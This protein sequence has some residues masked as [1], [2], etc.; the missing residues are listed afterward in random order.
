MVIFISNSKKHTGELK[1]FF[2]LNRIGLVLNPQ[3]VMLSCSSFRRE[4]GHRFLICS[5][6]STSPLGANHGASGGILDSCVRVQ[7]PFLF[8]KCYKNHQKHILSQQNSDNP[9]PQNR[10]FRVA[11]FVLFFSAWNS[12]VRHLLDV[13]SSWIYNLWRLILQGLQKMGCS[14]ST[15]DNWQRYNFQWKS[16][17]PRYHHHRCFLKKG[18]QQK[19]NLQCEWSTLVTLEVSKKNSP[20]CA[21]VFWGE[22]FWEM[23]Y[24][25]ED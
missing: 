22:D 9:P 12:D 5:S 20:R 14:K 16:T 21:D 8:L 13:F 11:L 6:L 7:G 25:P 19:H 2:R 23:V 3:P 17:P 4:N 1:R 18:N 15:W 10:R 24:T